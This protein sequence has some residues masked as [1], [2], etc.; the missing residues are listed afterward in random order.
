MLGTIL[1]WLKEKERC[2]NM[3]CMY[4]EFVSGSTGANTDFSLI[5]LTYKIGTICDSK[6][7]KL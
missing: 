2:V 7:I 4:C 6:F 3:H 5:K 1:T